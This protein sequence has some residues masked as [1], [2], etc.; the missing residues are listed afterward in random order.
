MRPVSPRPHSEDDGVCV[1][2]WEP[3]AAQTDLQ[4]L[5]RTPRTHVQIHTDTHS[6][7]G[8]RWAPLSGTAGCP[9]PPGHQ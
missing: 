3:G 8:G 1:H 2:L 5:T 4:G 7:K 9:P 6:H